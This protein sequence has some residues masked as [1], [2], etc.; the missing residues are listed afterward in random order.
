MNNSELFTSKENDINSSYNNGFARVYE[1]KAGDKFDIAKEEIALVW[2]YNGN[3]SLGVNN[4]MVYLLGNDF[5]YSTYTSDTNCF[6]VDTITEG[7]RAF[8]LIIKTDIFLQ[9]FQSLNF[10]SLSYENLVNIIALSGKAAVIFHYPHSG[11]LISSMEI[12]ISDMSSEYNISDII[13]LDCVRLL[14]NISRIEVKEFS[15]LKNAP[16]ASTVVYV[17]KYIRENFATANLKNMAQNLNYSPAYLSNLLKDNYGMS[18]QQMVDWRRAVVANKLLL[19][20]DM[21]LEDIAL[22]LGFESY[23]GFYKFWFKRQG[24]S[25]RAYRQEYSN[26]NANIDNILRKL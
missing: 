20:S 24:K 17:L 21:S 25:P 11:K 4:G 10:K 23:A 8:V 22:H 16:S 2:V 12:I 18:F 15:P 14:E 1:C 3:V 13:V 5:F 9:E 19:K 6:W 26:E 7:T